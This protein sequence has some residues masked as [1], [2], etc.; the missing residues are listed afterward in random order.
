MRAR[1]QCIGK[2]TALQHKGHNVAHVRSRVA[3][4]ANRRSPKKS[5]WLVFF[6]TFGNFLTNQDTAKECEQCTRVRGT[7]LRVSDLQK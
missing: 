1:W 3:R 5:L 4:E 7:M 6:F 2:T